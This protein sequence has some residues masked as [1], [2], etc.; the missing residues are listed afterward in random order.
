MDLA[1]LWKKRA[2]IFTGLLRWNLLSGETGVFREKRSWF[3][4]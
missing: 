3:D 1:Q 2:K 4:L